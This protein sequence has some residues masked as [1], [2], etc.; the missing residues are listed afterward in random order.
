MKKLLLSVVFGILAG[1]IDITPMLI[2]GVD[3]HF[4]IS[5]FLHWVVLGFLIT[6]TVLDIK[7]WLKGL[8][9][10]ELSALPVVFQ[11]GIDSVIPIFAMSAI[12][13]SFIGFLSD[14][15]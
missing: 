3:W 10:A 15:Y 5:P 13:G 8:F 12:L 11:P 9:I 4:A 7:P 14:R 1:I 2:R 6:Y